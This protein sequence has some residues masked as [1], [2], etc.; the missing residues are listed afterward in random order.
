MSN[1]YTVYDKKC[2]YCGHKIEAVTYST[3][4]DYIDNYGICRNCGG[5]FKVVMDFKLKSLDD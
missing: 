1:F 3:A 5:K 4:V 2:P